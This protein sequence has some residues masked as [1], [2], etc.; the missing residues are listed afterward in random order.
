M[1]KFTPAE[2]VVWRA[3]GRWWVYLMIAITLLC[4]YHVIGIIPLIIIGQLLFAKV[5][6]LY[7]GNLVDQ[8][9]EMLLYYRGTK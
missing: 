1:M 2:K 3:L 4:S 9:L 7:E 8:E 6:P 5:K